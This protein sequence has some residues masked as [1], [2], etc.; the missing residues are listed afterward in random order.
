MN[1]NISKYLLGLL[2]A[3]LL[4]VTTPLAAEVELRLDRNR[5]TEGETVTLTFLTDNPKQSLD[6]DFT[7]LE[8]DFVILDRRSET[9]LSIVN[10]Q[11]TAL[12]R[13]LLT[14]EPLRTGTLTIPAIDFGSSSTKA[15]AL[16][17][18]K[19]PELEPGAL[20]PVFIEVE[21]SPKDG[22]YYVH[23]QLGLVV[24]VFYQ[25]NLTEAA[26]SQ[27][28][29]APASV[30]LLQETPYQAE[31]GGQ[32]YRVLERRYAI[33]PERSGEL[34]LP[35]MQL[36]GRLVE[37][38]DGSIWQP[39]VRGRRITVES[40]ALQL[41]IEPR[42]ASFTGAV[43]QP[44]R[45]F[46][47]SQQVS[48][49]DV[50]HVGEPVTR[51][52]I[53][54]AVGLEENMIAE[55]AWPDI[56]GVRIYPDQPQG[57]S[58]DDGEWVLGHK[59]FRYAVVPEQAGE[60]VLPELTVNWWDTANNRQQTA[61][62]PSQV[63]Q[64][65][66]S[67]SIPVSP[68][69]AVDVPGALGARGD[70]PSG[71]SAGPAYWR[72]LTFAFAALWL[73]TLALLWR[74]RGAQHA[75][76]AAQARQRAG[77]ADEADARRQLKQAC[78]RDDVAAARLSLMRWLRQFGPGPGAGL[79]DFAADCGDPELSAAIYALDSEGYRQI[80]GDQAAADES[81]DGQRFWSQFQSWHRGWR[82]RQKGQKPPL[83]DLYA[84]ANR[85][86]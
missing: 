66:P 59:E 19:A 18:D 67:A 21:V 8:N 84:A 54:D 31:R 22:P 20:P 58:R 39:T 44:A 37:R 40:E 49:S 33:F 52:I 74:L 80:S 4:V 76:A 73:A 82:E 16:R 13:L 10:G 56:S 45:S 47:L 6:A 69:A 17:V 15:M 60:L 50:L 26:I 14:V 1:A 77:E 23:A 61:V 48:S 25:Q 64:V 71:S 78:K 3:M 28:E 79:L 55:P 34:V 86:L 41:Q 72:W 63:L 85:T 38:R 81:W 5:V 62:L 2:A 46:N 12:V 11:Q 32:R 75:Q 65:K 57:I 24:R 30:R 29:P 9:Q 36:S 51:T 42:P 68:P 7:P 27:P 53:I 43:W 35:P 83:T 70:L